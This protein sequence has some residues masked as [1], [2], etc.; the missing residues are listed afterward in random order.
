MRFK[1]TLNIDKR[2]CGDKLPFNYQYE[3]SAVIYKILSKSDSKF[4]DWL[5]DN[6]FLA[7][8]KQFKLFAF[9]RLFIPRFR[10][11]DHM[12]KIVS[13]T[14]E[15]YISFV[16]EISTREFIQGIFKEQ[17]FE[18]GN[19][20]AR[21]KCRVQSIELMPPPIFKE[22]MMFETLSPICLTLKIDD[23]TDKYISPT[24][25]MALPLLKQNLL[26]KYKAANGF[27]FPDT[28]FPFEF[29]VI[30]QPKSSL[31][32]IKADT[33]Q[34]SKIRG[35]SCQ[36][37]MTA[38]EEIMQIAYDGGIGGKNSIGFGMIR[39]MENEINL[40]IKKT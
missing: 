33:P 26:D 36:F 4:S 6:G 35:F 15:W 22:N 11:E 9:S 12:L 28:D 34:E 27:P 19:K 24:H 14:I 38:P 39:E 5:H 32:T 29:K 30:T 13:D 8:K 37:T 3:C 16:P 23:G 1:I 21:I 2:E 20:K 25:P 7:N 17:E 31:I 10:I 18:L 40:K